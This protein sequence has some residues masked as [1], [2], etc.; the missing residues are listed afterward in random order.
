MTTLLLSAALLTQQVDDL[1]ARLSLEERVAQVCAVTIWEMKDAQ[2]RFDAEKA[3]RTVPHG[4]GHVCQFACSQR[5]DPE[6]VR[7]FVRDA[8]A[9]F[10]SGTRPGI[11]AIFHEEVISGFATR[12]ATVYPQQIGAAASFDPDLM[13]VKCRETGEAG[14]MVGCSFALSPMADVIYNSVWTRLEEGYGESGYLSAVMGTAFVEGL[15]QCESRGGRVKGLGAC[16]KH[17]LG[18]GDIGGGLHRDWKDIHEDVILP[19]E[20]MIRRADATAVMTS[21]GE[22]K[23]VQAVS[24]PLLVQ[25]LLRDYIGFNGAVVSDYGAVV[26]GTDALPEG[27]AREALQRRRAKEALLAGND[28]DLQYGFSYRHLVDMVRSGEI[29]E[30]AVERAVKRSLML[31]AR[32]GL[33]EKGAKLWSDGPVCLDRPEWRATARRLAEESVVLLKN[34]GV[35][36]LGAA[37]GSAPRVALVGPNANSDWAMLGDYTYHCM[38]AFWQRN[39]QLYATPHIVTLKEALSPD[40]YARGVD[41]SESGESV[42]GGGGD[43]RAKDLQLAVAGN[44]DETDFDKAVAAAAGADVIVAAMGENYTL[45]GEARQRPDDALP[46]RQAAFVKALLA[47]GRPVVLVLFGGRNLVLDDETAERCAAVLHAYYPGEEGGHAVADILRGVVSPS[48]RLPMTYPRV[49]DR[50]DLT[51]GDGTDTP[52]RARWPFG[53]GLGYTKFRYAADGAARVNGEWVEIPFRLKNV[54]ERAGTEVVQVYLKLGRTRLR[55]FGRISLDAGA[56]ARLVSRI[57]VESFAEWQGEAKGEWALRPGEYTV[58][59]GAS[60]WDTP[61]ERTVRLDAGRRFPVRN[62]FFGSIEEIAKR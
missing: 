15:Q 19:H 57:P 55:A 9:Y 25:G 59:I 8:Q 18:Y 60:A 4:I 30:S 11:P 12:G 49:V 38:Q 48:G 14:R 2:G 34:D 58:K 20:A 26:W 31:K 24:N 51:F 35:L 61:V 54:G 10:I 13:R 33:L 36:P 42:V 6:V 50:K 39:P 32:L 41:W 40:I 17:F 53:H 56:S 47:T 46:G 22:F 52:D 27:P 45:C 1:Y 43:A 7:D 3:R 44:Q 23:G 29:P 16:C 28:I 21:Y 62:V 5:N 37:G